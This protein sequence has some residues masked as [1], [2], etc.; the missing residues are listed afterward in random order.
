MQ[1]ALQ[2][3]ASEPGLAEPERAL[4]P[5]P[6]PFSTKQSHYLSH[7]PCRTL[8]VLLLHISYPSSLSRGYSATRTGRQRSQ[9]Q[10][11][12]RRQGRGEGGGGCDTDS[13][14]KL[15]GAGHRPGTGGRR[16]RCDSGGDPVH[17]GP[18]GVQFVLR[19]FPSTTPVFC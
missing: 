12:G 15:P 4:K 16:R 10:T 17:S 19:Q 18:K 6:F 8:L 5:P 3:P 9:T 2:H 1:T 14:F 11:L 7:D 13:Q